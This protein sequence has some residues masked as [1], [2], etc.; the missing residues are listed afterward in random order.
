MINS[1]RQYTYKGINYIRIDD[2]PEKLRERL[3]T[4]DFKNKIIKILTETELLSNC[5]LFT[6]FEDYIS[7][8]GRKSLFTEENNRAYSRKKNPNPSWLSFILNLNVKVQR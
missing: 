8:E 2:L 5:L 3:L 1:V 6:D 7:F 4:S